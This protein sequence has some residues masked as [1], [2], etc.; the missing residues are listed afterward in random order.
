MLYSRR[1]HSDRIARGTTEP[2]VYGVIVGDPLAK[3][4]GVL[5]PGTTDY[6]VNYP[7][8]SAS[9]S[10]QLGITDTLSHIKTV[11]AA[12]PGQKFA[13]AGYSQGAAVVNQALTQ[14]SPS[15]YDSIVAVAQFGDPANKGGAGLPDV[16]AQKRVQNCAF[17]DPVC[18][19]NGSDYLAHITY[20]NSGT[21]FISESASYIAKQL[22]NGGTSGPDDVNATP[23][24]TQ[25][26]GN[27]QALVDLL[28]FLKPASS[29]GNSTTSSNSTTST[30]SSSNSTMSGSNSTTSSTSSSNST[31]SGATAS[32]EASGSATATAPAT[33]TG[34]ASVGSVGVSCL[35]GS[36]LAM[37]LSF[38]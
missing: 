36:V 11:A 5:V 4:V 13:V 30:T 2:G 7:A 14:L 32:I 1:T 37:L 25:T 22:A 21:T 35:S 33:Y 23:P 31:S 28:N 3:A 18:S 29:S 6:A 19:N 27:S 26:A 17:G 9:N 16:L 38:L 20:M 34:G 15:M 10:Q 12:C 24:G 8:S